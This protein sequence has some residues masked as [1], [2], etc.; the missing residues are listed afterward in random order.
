MARSYAIT[1]RQMFALVIACSA[2]ITAAWSSTDVRPLTVSE[3]RK[4]PTSITVSSGVLRLQA[5]AWRNFMPIVGKHADPAVSPDGGGPMMVFFQLICSGP[6][7][8][9]QLHARTVWL[10]QGDSKWESSNIEQAA[11][12]L[13]DFKMTVHGGPYWSQRSH[14]DI[15][16]RFSDD[17]GKIFDLALRDSLIQAAS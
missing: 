5:E 13:D 7:P 15:V 14:F 10:L 4:V 11:D 17:D 9:K 16:V 6:R 1:C 12:A 8:S 3:L 2:T